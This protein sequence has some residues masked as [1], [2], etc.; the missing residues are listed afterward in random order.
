MALVG[1]TSEDP[2]PPEYDNEVA[3]S[4][5]TGIRSSWCPTLK[6]KVLWRRECCHAAQRHAQHDQQEARDCNR[7]RPWLL[8]TCYSRLPTSMKNVLQLHLR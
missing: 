1:G 8:L 3:Q 2:L 6:L 5:R 4:S 7:Q